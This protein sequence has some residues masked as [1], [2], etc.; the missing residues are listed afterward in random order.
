MKYGSYKD[1]SCQINAKTDYC[2]VI[3]SDI[4]KTTIINSGHI[5]AEDLN[6]CKSLHCHNCIT[7][8]QMVYKVVRVPE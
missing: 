4:L 8:C 5:E 7:V 6:C 3:G 1:A 2:A